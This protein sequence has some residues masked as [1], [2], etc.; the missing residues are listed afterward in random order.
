MSDRPNAI[1]YTNNDKSELEYLRDVESWA[2]IRITELESD[3]AE[4]VATHGFADFFVRDLKEEID[5]GERKIAELE[6]DRNCWKNWF[7]IARQ[8]ENDANNNLATL[9][10]A[11]LLVENGLHDRIAELKAENIHLASAILSALA[12]MNDQP[13]V[14]GEVRTILRNALREGNNQ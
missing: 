10:D 11:T 7:E 8:K 2:D 4:Y 14:I 9:I 5:E 6:E 1:E 12:T 13:S 3:H